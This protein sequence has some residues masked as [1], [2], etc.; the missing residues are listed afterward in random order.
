MYLFH[1]TPCVQIA[2]AAQR[3]C[4]RMAG[5]VFLCRKGIYS[6]YFF[7]EIRLVPLMVQF[8][9]N[10]TAVDFDKDSSRETNENGSRILPRKNADRSYEII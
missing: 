6:G 5:L 1:I 3:C 7:P 4:D 8:V 2:T 9:E 10:G